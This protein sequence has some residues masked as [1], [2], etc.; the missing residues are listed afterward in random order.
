MKVNNKEVNMTSLRDDAPD[1]IDVF[2]PTQISE[3]IE[4]LKS[5]GAQVSATESKLKEL[6]EQEKFISNFTIPEIMNKMN[7]SIY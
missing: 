3:A 5:V 2:D 7:L 1:Q 4:K 6:K